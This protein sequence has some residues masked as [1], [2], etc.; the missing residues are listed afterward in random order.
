[1]RQLVS[2]PIRLCGQRQTQVDSY[3]DSPSSLFQLF[4]SGQVELNIPWLG[5][6]SIRNPAKKQCRSD[7]SGRCVVSKGH[8]Q[9]KPSISPVNLNTNCELRTENPL[10]HA[11]LLS[12]TY[13]PTGM[14]MKRDSLSPVYPSQIPWLSLNGRGHE[15]QMK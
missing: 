10:Q 11:K 15:R 13:A 5:A 2:E 1:M 4:E 6:N 9:T 12:T 14:I 3:I 8:P 7:L